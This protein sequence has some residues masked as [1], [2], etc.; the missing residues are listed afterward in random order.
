[1]SSAIAATCASALAKLHSS[2]LAGG[3]SRGS[4]AATPCS[5]VAPDRLPVAGGQRAVV[6]DQAF[7]RLPGEIEPVEGA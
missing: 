5:R 2:S 7:E 4:A 3:Y 6:F 1:M